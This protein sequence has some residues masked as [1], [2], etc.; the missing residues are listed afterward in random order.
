MAGLAHLRRVHRRPGRRGR[1][2]RPRPDPHGSASAGQAPH[3]WRA[4]G[5]G[6]HD[7]HP[8]RDRRPRG[9]PALRRLHRPGHD[10]H[11]PSPLPLLR[12]R[13]PDRGRGAV[14][15]HRRGLVDVRRLVDGG[16]GRRLRRERGPG[17]GGGAGRPPRHRGRGVRLR[18]HR[19][20]PERAGHG[21]PHRRPGPL[22]TT[23]PVEDP[24][25][26]R[27]PQLGRPRLPGHGR[28]DRAGAGRRPGPPH[29]RGRT[30]RAGGTAR[31]RLL[32]RGR[33]CGGDQPGHRRRP[34][35]GGRGRRR[36]RPLV[37]RR[38]RLRRRRPR[39]PLRTDHC[40]PVSSGPTPSSSTPTSGCSR[41]STAVPSST[42]IPSPPGRP[43]PSTPP[44]STPSPS[45]TSGTRRTTP[46]TSA[47][48]PGACRSGSR[49]PCTAP[50]PTARPSRP[51]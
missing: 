41:P 5:H 21:P 48:G 40:S 43:T 14:R 34:R 23:G 4:P 27:G 29:R 33:H 38:R 3:P 31:R 6:R 8:R 30:Q 44:T 35:R 50:T 28:R 46:S 7:H 42:G 25:E 45:G 39:A 36:G 2:L 22:R 26:C 11:R 24:G 15:P 47:A 37:P 9:V 16:L 17:V 49:W 20:Q 51:R 10:L 13:R 19:R 18:W 1:R 12:A 32:R